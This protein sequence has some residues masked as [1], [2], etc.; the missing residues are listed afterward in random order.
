MRFAFAGDRDISVSVL[1]FILSTGEK[2]LALLVS[3][4]KKATHANILREK[5]SF[6][7]DNYVFEG[8]DFKNEKS[9]RM[10]RVLDLDF[11]ISVHF[12]YIIN[13]EVINIP[14][15]GFINLHPAYLPYN[16]GWHT[17]SWAILEGTPIGGTLHFMDE[18][19]DSGDIILQKMIE[20]LPN[21]TA[22][23]LYRAIK[24]CEL[25][26]FKEAWP[27]LLDGTYQRIKQVPFIGTF[28]LK[29]DL[30]CKEVQYIDL[31]KE[32]TPKE[33]INKLRALSTSS[34]EEAAYFE[35]QGRKYKI[36]VQI[37]ETE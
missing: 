10:L 29:R 30:F 16:K 13:K 15:F 36:Q 17:P 5:C 35:V 24:E 37:Y 22:D 32:C 33:L 21:Y 2:P 18:G 4:K 28:H 8:T 11:I 31:E 34:L 20:V 1:D 19:V 7:N 6:L 12:P 27:K 3:S 9:I 23:S 25:S 26:V 14:K